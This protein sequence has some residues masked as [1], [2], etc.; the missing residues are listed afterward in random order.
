[1]VRYQLRFQ[2]GGIGAGL[3]VGGR[4]CGPVPRAY[5][6][7]DATAFDYEYG[8]VYH[9]QTTILRKRMPNWG[10]TNHGSSKPLTGLN[11][12]T[13]FDCFPETNSLLEK[14]RRIRS[15]HIFPDALSQ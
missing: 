4:R 7:V 3:H 1:M 14:R 9:K 15:W 6:D 11:A 8:P 5:H 13:G 12:K 2:L 10:Q